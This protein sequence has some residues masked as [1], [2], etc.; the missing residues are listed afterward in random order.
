MARLAMSVVYYS[1]SNN[2]NPIPVE[3][4]NR[5]LSV[6]IERF[7]EVLTHPTSTSG[8]YTK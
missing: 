5:L 7:K 4:S 3:L 1:S 6:L 2:A 8:P